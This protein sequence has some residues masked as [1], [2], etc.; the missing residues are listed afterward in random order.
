MQKYITTETIKIKEE[1]IFSMELVLENGETVSEQMRTGKYDDYQK[2]LRLKQNHFADGRTRL[3]LIDEMRN[4][5][6]DMRLCD[7]HNVLDFRYRKY[8][9]LAI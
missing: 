9:E 4:V 7:A 5:Y 3:I 6:A 1:G 8:T 2:S